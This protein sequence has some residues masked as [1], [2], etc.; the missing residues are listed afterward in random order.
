M[1]RCSCIVSEF[2]ISLIFCIKLKFNVING[3]FV[4]LYRTWR[5][6]SLHTHTVNINFYLQQN[7]VIKLNLG[8]NF[9]LQFVN[10]KYWSKL[11]VLT[12]FP[13]KTK[14]KFG[15]ITC[16][17]FDILFTAATNSIFKQ[18]SAMISVYSAHE[19]QSCL[20]L[21]K[22]KIG[23]FKKTLKRLF[24]EQ[25]AKWLWYSWFGFLQRWSKITQKVYIW[26]LSQNF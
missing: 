21:W 3:V 2:Q 6:Y 22:P 19:T 11:G 5:K 10:G 25:T 16:S 12:L 24:V 15:Y 18:H 23:E 8:V 20:I 4:P 9:P 1:D 7:D 14:G 17:N 13:G 26:K